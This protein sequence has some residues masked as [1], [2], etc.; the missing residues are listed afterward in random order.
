MNMFVVFEPF[1]KSLTSTV[2][3]ITSAFS[4][5]GP[6]VKGAFA[7]G[8]AAL[9][10]LF[11]PA[12]QIM[13]G[14]LFRKGFDS[15][16]AGGGGIASLFKKGGGAGGGGIS[17][18]KGAEGIP[19]KGKPGGFLQSLS[20][21]LKSFGTDS[22]K[23]IKGASTLALS[24]LLIGGAL[25][26]ITAGIAKFGGDASGSQ[27]LTFGVALVGLAGSL[28]LMS[29]L[30][31]QMS[32]GDVLKGSMAM[33]ILGLAMVPFAYSM[34]L[35]QKV[36][37]G[38][39][40]KAAVAI[41][42]ASL[43]LAGMS[44]L[45]GPILIGALALAGA[46]V[47]LT[48]FGASLLVAA[49]GFNA[50]SKIDWAS[51]SG[52]GSALLAILPGLIGLAGVGLFA[53]PGLVM[54]SFALGGL[55][56]VMAILAPSMTMAAAATHSMASGVGELK[57]AVKGLDT[58][59]LESLASSAER[60]SVS[61]ALGGIANAIGSAIGGGSAEKETKIKLEPITINLKFNGRD[62]QQVI[63]ND[64]QLST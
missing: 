53:I 9:A 43:L 6:I 37:W 49:L 60:L 57:E 39:L 36:D 1:I 14:M 44:L 29:K 11:G 61:S 10:L 45:A 35:F 16:G 34:T 17:G 5:F 19:D 13:N 41:I 46:G 42:G 33:A 63:I 7:I 30:M 47:A 26:A 4:S 22:G 54:M 62:M 56:A 38:T 28:F 48:I 31:G 8:I 27:L 32:M 51:F 24:S 12:K 21:G 59:K 55:A 64:T 40:G 15:G 50:M 20:E 58:S 18:V 25:I 52:M 23:I 2:L 3:K